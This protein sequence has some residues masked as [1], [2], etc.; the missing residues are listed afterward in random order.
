MPMRFR[1]LLTLL[2]V[3]ILLSSCIRIPSDQGTDTDGGGSEGK[4]PFVSYYENMTYHYQTKVDEEALLTGL[5]TAYLVLANKTSPVGESYTPEDLVRL[6]NAVVVPWHQT[7]GL[8]LEACAAAALY[9]MLDEMRAE[10]V[11]DIF[12]TSAY[13]S[14]IKQ[15]QLYY[16]YL[17]NELST[18][19]EDAYRCLGYTYIKVN[20]LDQGKTQLSRADAEKVVLSYSAYPGT[21]EHQTGLCVDFITEDMGG[22]LTEAFEDTAAFAWLSENAYKFGFIL[23]YPKGKEDITGYTYEP[24]HY[25]FVGR[26]AAT[27]IHFSRLTLEQYLEN[28]T[29]H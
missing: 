25:R 17:D 8:T 11:T 13:R 9:E 5:D 18:I 3:P 28:G 6:D 26:E 4:D 27:D 23:R 15:Q 16:Q 2:C 7:T 21:S 14:Y 20:Y 19:S 10:E 12:V 29:S 22:N 24:W 1:K